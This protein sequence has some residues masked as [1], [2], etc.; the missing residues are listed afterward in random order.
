MT[1]YAHR[2]RTVKRT[3]KPQ[4]T[5]AIT[6]LCQDWQ[7]ALKVANKAPRTIT[8]YTACV[9]RYVAA[10]ADDIGTLNK[11][12]ITRWLADMAE[13]HSQNH[14]RTHYASLRLFC[15]W[16]VKEDELDENPMLD[17]DRPT[18][19]V[20]P[21]EPYTQDEVDALL[22]TCAT[23]RFT[24]RRDEAIIRLLHVSGLRLHELATIT[25]EAIDFD[26]QRIVVLGK[27]RKVR[28]VGYDDDTAAAI[29]KYR[30]KRHSHPD[31][32]LAQFWLGEKGELSDEGIDMMLRRRARRAGVEGVHAHR[33]R[34]TFADNWLSDGGG[35]MS[36][37]ALAGWS[38]PSML[39]RYTDARAADR[40][41]AEYKRLRK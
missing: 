9:R 6:D 38:N 5:P 7:A 14:V 33:F 10:N 35:E 34:H 41:L 37:M 28:V 22:A 26:E 24:D 18:V 11:R 2:I 13:A 1:T 40:A 31:H 8:T 32:D 19:K 16:L 4:G 36:L 27:G 12:T 15:A 21:V 30:R 29:R 25:A 3:S 20:I 23:W 17:I 39:K